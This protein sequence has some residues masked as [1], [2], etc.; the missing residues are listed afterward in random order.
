MA[1]P[2]SPPATEPAEARA[3]AQPPPTAGPAAAAENARTSDDQPASARDDSG[4]DRTEHGSDKIG[5]D[6]LDAASKQFAVSRAFD[7]AMHTFGLQTNLQINNFGEAGRAGPLPRQATVPGR[8]LDRVRSMWAEPKGYRELWDRV[9]DRALVITTGGRGC[10][11]Q[12]AATRILDAL[13]D[14]RVRHLTSGSV[15]DLQTADL[16]ENTGYLW[17]DLN[18]ANDETRGPLH[19]DRLAETLQSRGS[20][21][22]IVTPPEVAWSFLIEE[23]RC[24]LTGPPDLSAVL[25][26]HLGASGERSAEVLDDPAVT[27]ARQRLGSAEQ[28]ARLG[29]ALRDVLAGRITPEDAV[30]R[31]GAVRESTAQWFAALPDREDRALALALAALNGLSLPTVMAGARE[32]DE[33]IQRAEDPKGRS[34]IRPFE[35][36]A[37][38]LFAAVQAGT[39]A[40]TLQ[41]SYGD[42]PITRLESRR[43]RFPREMLATMWTD[44]PYLQGIY[45][46]WLGDL[47]HE[48]RDPYVR[49]RAAVATGIL[50]ESD[51]DFVRARVLDDWAVSDNPVV[52]RAAGVALRVPAG[53]DR[54]GAIVWAMLEAWATERKDRVETDDDRWRRMT[55]AAA[56]G[57]PVGILDHERALDL[58][59]NRL[60][61]YHQTSWYAYWLTISYA[62]VELLSDG[63]SAQS[64]VIVDRLLKWARTTRPAHMNV[65][66]MALIGIVGRPAQE[67][68]D[69]RRIPPVLRAAGADAACRTSL[70]ALWRL[71]LDYRST[72]KIATQAVRKLAGNLADDGDDVFLDLVGA[73]PQTPREVRTLAYEVRHWCEEEPHPDILDRLHDRL[74]RMEVAR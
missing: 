33:L 59:E 61:E 12:H 52:R 40:A 28:A 38:A 63:G 68:P 19:L 36:P 46:R 4:D 21:M 69:G 67:A 24:D 13:C 45:L 73:V 71:A 65:A 5:A 41:T 18:A 14:G 1:A 30:R 53:N 11:A 3:P 58:I 49:E 57:G 2:A 70:A 66:I 31:A 17:T 32:L 50:A 44:F 43:E 25:R 56:L 62:V 55:A 51:F 72:S 10:G 29:T 6:L 7:A 39:S 35:R 60:L 37:R 8:S 34:A 15:T 54:L 23:H 26:L 9:E 74:R 47:V 42:V 22:I 20:R 16:A 27:A 48:H 64:R